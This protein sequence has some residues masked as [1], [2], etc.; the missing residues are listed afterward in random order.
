[1]NF[2]VY[3]ARPRAFRL[4]WIQNKSKFWCNDVVCTYLK[5]KEFKWLFRMLWVWELP[6]T[7]HFIVPPIPVSPQK[8]NIRGALSNLYS[9]RLCRVPVHAAQ[10][11]YVGYDSYKH[12]FAPNKSC[13]DVMSICFHNMPLISF[14]VPIKL[15]QFLSATFYPK[16]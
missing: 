13:L 7:V 9:Y 4:K 2:N 11:P 6:G 12:L 5:W 8:E 16:Y 3:K 15:Q 1:M 10:A 14:L